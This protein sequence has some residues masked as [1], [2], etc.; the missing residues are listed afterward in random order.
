M[1]YITI[2]II[3]LYIIYLLS[4]IYNFYIIIKFKWYIDYFKNLENNCSNITNIKY[5]YETFRYNLYSFLYDK[6]GY[7]ECKKIFELFNTLS[8]TIL[9]IFVIILIFMIYTFSLLI[10][11]IIYYNKVY[12]LEYLVNPI[13]NIILFIIFNSIFIYIYINI[14]KFYKN[15]NNNLID[16]NSKIFKYVAVYNILNIIMSLDYMKKEVLEYNDNMK[17]S[18]DE[19][20]SKKY[21]LDEIIEGNIVNIEDKNNEIFIKNIKNKSYNNNDILKYITLNN[22]SPYYFNNYFDNIYITF[23]GE[24]K[25]YLKDLYKNNRDDNKSSIYNNLNN[26]INERFINGFNKIVINIEDK[27][28]IKYLIENIQILDDNKDNELNDL[29]KLIDTFNISLLL[30]II[31]ISYIILI[32]FHFAYIYF[33]EKYQIY[34]IYLIVFIIIS[35]Y[36]YKYLTS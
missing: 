30:Y 7:D 36:I 11:D 22:S 16:K 29:M 31:V 25:I 34:I 3:F 12:E 23:D 10:R 9:L 17:Y 18:N 19:E 15:L 24:N 8:I 2:L 5:E 14:N 20:N 13:I 33:Q 35:P 21:T 27:D 4:I 6:K 26:Y 1:N 28:Y 32:I